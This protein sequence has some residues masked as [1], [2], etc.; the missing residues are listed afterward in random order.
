MDLEEEIIALIVETS[1]QA[2][3]KELSKWRKAIAKEAGRLI[4]ANL[5][6]ATREYRETATGITK[7]AQA[8]R[9]AIQ[10]VNSVQTAIN[11]LARVV[12]FAGKLV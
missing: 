11:A 7:A 3:R 2:Q 12:D 1:D 6:A 5:D 4:D 8:T 9:R 10:K